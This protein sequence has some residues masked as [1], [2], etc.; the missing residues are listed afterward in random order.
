MEPMLPPSLDDLGEWPELSYELGLSDGL[1]VHPPRRDVVEDLVAGSGRRGDEL[2]A[3]IPPRDGHATVEVIAANAAMAGALPE[4]MPVIIAAIEAMSAPEHNL[5]G[6][7][8]T[9]HPCWPL[10]IVSGDEVTRLGMAT[11]ESVF[12]GGGSRANAA[13]G[14][15]V[16]LV[17]W[18]TGGARPGEPVKEVF[19]HP[20]RLGGYCI[21]ESSASPWEPFHHARGLDEAS[22]VTVFAC[23][24]PISVAA[25]GLD[26]DPHNRLA[27]AAD[28]LTLRGSNNMHTMGEV[29]VVLTPSEAR[30][31][32]SRGYGR[33]DVQRELFELARRSIGSIRPRS[34]ARP[35]N[36]P[37]HWYT[38]WPEWVDQSD[39]DTLVPVVES[40]EDIHVLVS[41]ADSIPWMAV[42]NGWGNLGGLAVTRSLPSPVSTTAGDTP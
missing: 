42:C 36:S 18:N 10:V 14:R 25:W 13:I 27:Q 23:E 35:D 12:G 22:G 37:E 34:P 38:W 4:H 41:G 32:A 1:P 16:K 30:H 40:P 8:L 5:R 2:V 26:D 19:G 21:A 11:E 7:L 24:S 9:T 33:A 28:S 20:G 3:I 17:L 31:L 6:L 39:D 29:L 15:A